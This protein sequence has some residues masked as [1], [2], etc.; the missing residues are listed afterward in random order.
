MAM[1]NTI[2]E[3]YIALRSFGDVT[4]DDTG[5][6]GE[7]SGQRLSNIGQADFSRDIL[8]LGTDANAVEIIGWA[9]ATENA[10]FGC[11]LW[12][13][14]WSGITT[15][16]ADLTGT[17]G[18]A[19]ADVTDVDSSARLFLDDITVSE[20]GHLRAIGVADGGNDRICKLAFDTLGLW[21]LYG[22]FYNVGGANECKRINLWVRPY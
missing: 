16:I 9:E 14:T 10:S 13:L 1:L 3:D 20:W 22:R 12:G 4:A 7:T 11:E 5:F 2:Q 15:L 18:T 19:W 6:D 21:G 8:S 17:A